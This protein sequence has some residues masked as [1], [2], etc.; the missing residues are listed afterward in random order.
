MLD[1]DIIFIKALTVDCWVDPDLSIKFMQLLRSD[2]V[3]TSQDYICRNE[4]ASPGPFSALM[5]GEGDQYYALVKVTAENFL[6][7]VLIQGCFTIHKCL[8]LILTPTFVQI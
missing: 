4:D 7:R 3:G 2:I 1:L 6:F 5:V 8:V